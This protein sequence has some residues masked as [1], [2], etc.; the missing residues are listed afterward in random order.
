MRPV[1][2]SA[3][4]GPSV[5]PS[6][7]GLQSARPSTVEQTG[8]P[9]VEV[10]A[11]GGSTLVL[12]M[13]RVANVVGYCAMYE[14][15]DLICE[16]LQADRAAPLSD[17]GLEFSRRLYKLT[18]RLTNSTKVASAVTPRLGAMKLQRDYELFLPVFNHPHE[19]FNLNAVQGWRDRCRFAAAYI[20]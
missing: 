6:V 3:I 13:R 4:G 15:E 16:L 18:R 14:F 7:P 10:V 5:G 8:T 9:S 17:E 1:A 2:R 20:C 19:L 12:S 11:Q